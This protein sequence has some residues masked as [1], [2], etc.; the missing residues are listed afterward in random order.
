MGWNKK[1]HWQLGTPPDSAARDGQPGTCHCHMAPHAGHSPQAAGRPAASPGGHLPLHL[2]F[3]AWGWASQAPEHNWLSL[4]SMPTPL[5]PAATGGAG[6]HSPSPMVGSQQL[7]SWASQVA[8]VVKNPPANAGDIRDVG[9]I[10]GSGRFPWRRA[11]QPTP[12]FL[13]EESH[14][15]RSLV[16][17]SLWHLK[18]SDTTEAT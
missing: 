4:G 12:V 6:C 10:P 13:P 3:T 1:E 11:W 2:C 18:E 5:S 16:G 7:L 15:Q 17:Y 14:G 9:S 8:P